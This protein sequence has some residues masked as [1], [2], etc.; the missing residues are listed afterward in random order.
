MGTHEGCPYPSWFGGNVHG[1][2]GKPSPYCQNGSRYLRGSFA[3][4]DR[5][6]QDLGGNIQRLI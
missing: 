2:D 3:Y 6:N 4:A 1:G 5:A